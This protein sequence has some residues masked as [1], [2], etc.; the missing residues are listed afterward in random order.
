M[1]K[2]IFTLLVLAGINWLLLGIFGWEVGRIFG[3]SEDIVSRIIY[4]LF[5]L[6]AVYEFATHKHR[7]KSCEV[8]AAAPTPGV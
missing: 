2:I 7:C 8:K 5:G 3:G 6:S 1:H 4:I